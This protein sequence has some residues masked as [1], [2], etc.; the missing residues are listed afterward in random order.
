MSA[1]A[2]SLTTALSVSA[3]MPMLRASPLSALVSAC[4]AAAASL[5]APLSMPPRRRRAGFGPL[6]P[7]VAMPVTV[8][9]FF[10]A[11]RLLFRPATAA[12]C[13]RPHDLFLSIALR[14]HDRLLF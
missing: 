13:L 11:L 12:A 7:A 3:A 9:L 14:F 10:S 6:L 4:L 2:M 8:L 1:L 5:S